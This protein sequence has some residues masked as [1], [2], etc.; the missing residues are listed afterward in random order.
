[1][2]DIFPEKFVVLENEMKAFISNYID[3]I[4]SARHLAKIMG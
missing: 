3:T 1:M 4:R 2:L